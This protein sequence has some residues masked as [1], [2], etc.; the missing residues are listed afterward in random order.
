M[1]QTRIK[2]LSKQDWIRNVKRIKRPRYPRGDRKCDYTY[3]PLFCDIDQNECVEQVYQ[4]LGGIVYTF[5]P[6]LNTELH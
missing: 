4:S 3:R 5:R 1:K 2:K 6:K